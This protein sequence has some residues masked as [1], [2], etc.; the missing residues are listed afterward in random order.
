MFEIKLLLTLAG[1]AGDMSEEG[2]VATK[3]LITAVGHELPA[4][5]KGYVKQI[6]S[7]AIEA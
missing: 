3:T 4:S 7:F 6:C 1:D 2:V 5:N